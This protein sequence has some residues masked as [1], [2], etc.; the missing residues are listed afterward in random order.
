[1]KARCRRV[2]TRDPETARELADRGADAVYRGNPIMDLAGDTIGRADDGEDKRVL[3]L[4]GSRER[5]YEDL[6]LLLDATL[7]MTEEEALRFAMV[8]APT[9]DPGRLL[10]KAP[11][12]ERAPGDVIRTRD[13]LSRWSFFSATCRK[14]PSAWR[15]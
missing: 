3:L 8:V 9:L 13:G 1:M 15:S 6:A 12:W 10:E 5:A 7:L 11:S 2:F 4:P 14:Q